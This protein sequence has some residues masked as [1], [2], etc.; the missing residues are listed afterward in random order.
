MVAGDGWTGEAAVVAFWPEPFAAG[1][2][3]AA[4]VAVVTAVVAFDVAATVDAA[5]V[6]AE[7]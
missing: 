5:F 7:A 6:V 2:G 3:A 4:F 1:G